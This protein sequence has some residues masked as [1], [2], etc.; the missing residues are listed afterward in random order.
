MSNK[1]EIEQFGELKDTVGKA[2]RN[3]MF[4]TIISM[5]VGISFAHLFNHLNT[6]NH[7][8]AAIGLYSQV[9][10][11]GAAILLSSQ[12]M[13]IPEKL[14]GVHNLAVAFVMSLPTYVW[15]SARIYVPISMVGGFAHSEVWMLV[16]AIPF[17]GIGMVIF[18]FG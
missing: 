9:I 7:F 11:F 1:D 2:R 10:G 14:F 3:T 16:T 5:M 12:F 4:M 6:S 18:A 8:I 13:N 17:W 15:L